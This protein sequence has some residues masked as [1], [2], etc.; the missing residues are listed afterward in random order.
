[1][2]AIKGKKKIKARISNRHKRVLD[3][4]YTYCKMNMV[5]A[6]RMAGYATPE[7]YSYHF[8]AI[9]SLNKPLEDLIEP[10]LFADSYNFV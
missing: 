9:F 5:E 2:S 8:S 6:L 4:Y 3:F 10:M 7:T 1:M